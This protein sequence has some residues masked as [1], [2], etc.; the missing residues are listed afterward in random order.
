MNTKIH[1]LGPQTVAAKLS[2]AIVENAKEEAERLNEERRS[3]EQVRS[4]LTPENEWT[5]YIQRRWIYTVLF[6]YLFV[7]LAA[8]F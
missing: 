4:F 8:S 5:V 6:F 7:Y 2:N 1:F 3:R